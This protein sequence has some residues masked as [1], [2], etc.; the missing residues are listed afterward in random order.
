MSAIFGTAIWD[1]E[2]SF[3]LSIR[4][5]TLY[6]FTRAFYSIIRKTSRRLVREK[7]SRT[8]TIERTAAAIGSVRRRAVPSPFHDRVGVR[9]GLQVPPFN[10][11]L[12]FV[13]LVFTLSISLLLAKSNV[14]VILIGG[15]GKNGSSVAVSKTANG[16]GRTC[17]RRRAC[18]RFAG[19]Q[20]PVA[21]HP[22]AVG[23]TARVHYQL[24]EHGEHLRNAP[25]A[26]HNGVRFGHRENN[27]QTRGER[28]RLTR[29]GS[30]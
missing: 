12:K 16:W 2:V 29:R 26:V 13:L 27:E 9:C 4:R 28:W 10:V 24:Q 30:I 25:G 5:V 3:R 21:G 8:W 14:S 11:K 15:V 23:D 7:L 6:T 17:F 19:H 22:A 20:R 18:F 1:Y